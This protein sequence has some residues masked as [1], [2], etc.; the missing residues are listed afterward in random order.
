MDVCDDLQKDS[1]TEAPKQ[2]TDW[3]RWISLAILFVCAIVAWKSKEIVHFMI[4]TFNDLKHR[5]CKPAAPA[6]AISKSDLMNDFIGAQNDM[7]VLSQMEEMLLDSSTQCDVSDNSACQYTKPTF[8][9]GPHVTILA[10]INAAQPTVKFGEIEE[11]EADTCAALGDAPDPL[12]D[13]LDALDALKAPDGPDLPEFPE[14]PEVTDVPDVPD[15]PDGPD[16][17][18]QTDATNGT[19]TLDVADVAESVTV[20]PSELEAPLQDKRRKRKPKTATT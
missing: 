18:P 13:A 11:I 19:C 1:Q 15:G 2:R 20:E 4:N 12:D 3:T 10:S 8:E 5:F 17:A 6:C 9:N 16:M 14:F 7:E